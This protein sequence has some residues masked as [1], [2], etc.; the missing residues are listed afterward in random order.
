MNLEEDHSIFQGLNIPI[1]EEAISANNG[2][3]Q[4]GHKWFSQKS[5]LP[6]FAEVVLQA[7]E[8]SIQK[9]R[10]YDHKSLPYPWGEVAYF[11]LRYIT[12][13]E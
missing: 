6:E 2:L 12:C 8:T 13:E 9:G 3:P 7:K 1:I 11:V 4:E 10:G 5:P